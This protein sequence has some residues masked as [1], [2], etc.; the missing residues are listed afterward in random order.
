MKKKVKK[1]EKKLKWITL[2]SIF[3]VVILISILVWTIYQSQQPVYSIESRVSR[4]NKEQQKRKQNVTAWVRVQGT[5]IDYPVIQNTM[6]LNLG[7][8]M[9]DFAWTNN[10]DE[11]FG[12]REIIMG[13]NILN[14]SKHP[15]VANENH[16]RFEQLASFMYYDFARKNQYIQYTINGVDHLYKIF[17]VGFIDNEELDASTN[18]LT[19]SE[20]KKHIKIAKKESFYRYS[21]DVDESDHILTLVTCTRFFGV[22]SDKIFRID[23]REVREDEKILKYRVAESAK[24]DKIKEEMEGEEEYEEA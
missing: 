3:G 11:K 12:N 10:E 19:Q 21:I 9:Y 18:N 8:L 5:N 2:L 22:D 23:A 20:L 16:H 4:I 7:A 1:C 17:A 14:V 13:H 15:L 6:E 24:Y